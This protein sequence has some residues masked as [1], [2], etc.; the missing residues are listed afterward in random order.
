VKGDFSRD[1]FSPRKHYSAVLM[2][3]GRVQ[4]DAD[5]NEQR[6]I[7]RHRIEAEA[8]DLFGPSGTGGGFGISVQDGTLG[9]GPGNLYVEGILCQNEGPGDGSPLLFEDQADLPPGLRVPVIERLTGDLD[10][11]LVYLDVWE[12]HVSA[13]DD[14]GIREVALGG[15]DTAT[16]SRTVWQA[17]VLRVEA[18]TSNLAALQ[19]LLERHAEIVS[20]LEEDP[21]EARAGALRAELAR[22]DNRVLELLKVDC[23]GAFDDLK[24]ARP[25]STGRLLA[26]ALPPASTESPC[27]LPADAGYDRL[28]NQLYRVEVHRAGELANAAFKWSRDNGSVATA[29][30]GLAPT[31]AGTEISVR[32]LGRDEVLGFAN[33]QYVELVDDATELAGGAGPLMQVV[34]VS[35]AARTITV[36]ETLTAVDPQELRDFHYKLRRWDSAGALPAASPDGD[37]FV[38]L[39][40]GI[41]VRFSEGTYKTGDYWLVPARSA[42]GEIEWPEDED[43][44]PAGIEHRYAPLALVMAAT[45]EG[46]RRLLVLSDCRRLFPPVTESSVFFYP[47]GGDGQEAAPGEPLPDPL[48]VGVSRG[49]RPVLGARVRFEVD[50]EDLAGYDGRLEA[51]GGT[52]ISVVATTDARGE[53]RCSWRLATG[54]PRQRVRAS[55]VGGLHPPVYFNATLSIAGEAVEERVRIT[56]VLLA[57]EQDLRLDGVVPADA[58]VKGV[59]VVCD[60]GSVVDERTLLGGR[61]ACTV[62]LEMP[63]PQNRADEEVW[64]EALLGFQPLVL[65]ANV[66]AEDGVISWEP[67]EDTAAWLRDR[68]FQNIRRGTDRILAHLK[69]KGNFIWDDERKE[70]YLDGEVFGAPSRRVSDVELV[71]PSGDGRRGGDFEMWFWLVP[72]TL[73][74]DSVTLDEDEVTGGVQMP[75][76][77]VTIIGTAPADGATIALESSDPEVASVPES[78]QIGA[79]Q[80]SQTF[81][82]T[83]APTAQSVTATITAT[84]TTSEETMQRSVELVVRPPAL[85]AV[86]VSPK[87][88]V[89]RKETVRGTVTLTGPAPASGIDVALESS[90]PGVVRLAQSSV[91]VVGTGPGEFQASTEPVGSPTPVTITATRGAERQTDTLT[92]LPPPLI[93]LNLDQ[94][95][96]RGG[97]ER[98]GTVEIDGPAPANFTVALDSTN[99]AVATVQPRSVEVPAGSTTSAQFRVQTVPVAEARETN[100]V[101]SRGDVILSR[102]LRVEP[103]AMTGFTFVPP[104]IGGGQTSTGRITLNGRTPP[105]TSFAL[106]GSN[107]T[108]ASF[109]TTPVTVTPDV[110]ELTFTATGR[111]FTG[112]DRSVTVTASYLGGTRPATLTVEGAKEKEDKEEFKDKE[113]KEEFKDKEFLKDKELEDKEIRE[114]FEESTFRRSGAEGPAPVEEGSGG[115]GPE[116][117]GRTFIRPEARPEVGRRALDRPEEGG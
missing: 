92:V 11:R 12:R 57:D 50:A 107:S 53:A 40:G 6:A 4:V 62:T 23:E 86:R 89:G 8:R 68:L 22:T 104:S 30:L 110:T 20:Q 117:S 99:K 87:T 60:E 55:L 10:V 38:D 26:R 90:N 47:V 93:R 95:P 54:R 36:N 70:A 45:V 33:G 111:I 37:G 79:G 74:L 71:L 65:L 34:D 105:N 43:L 81:E 78:V 19:P 102:L 97:Q 42:T 1:T 51:G 114:N 21:D 15:P 103:P 108:T 3:Q 77:T 88:T 29:V 84:L 16:R 63:F 58:F 115:S 59:R 32:D 80:T 96:M 73:I 39:E 49:E 75:T 83:T 69:L 7:D 31:G 46:E 44:P 82:V 28:E 24:A 14:D 113:D 85:Q 2:Q 61:P 94:T 98:T 9:I 91:R 66:S 41:Q 100:I 109:P 13:L 18:N 25:P 48:V 52:G 5:W 116:R 112:A 27:V 17:D 56:R 67:A 72:Q 106:S 101:A 76:G 35:P 64:G